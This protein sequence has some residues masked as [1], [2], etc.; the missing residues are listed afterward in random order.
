VGNASPVGELIDDLRGHGVRR[1][2][3][4]GVLGD[5]THATADRGRQWIEA[6]TSKAITAHD[7]LSES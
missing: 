2:S 5:P 1:V 6:L 3:P 7:R 4:N